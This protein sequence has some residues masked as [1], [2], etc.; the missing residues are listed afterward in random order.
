M[1]KVRKQNLGS[2]NLAANGT[3]SFDLP[4]EFI[5]ARYYL[6]LIGELNVTVITTNINESPQRL[7]RRIDLVGDGETLQTWEGGALFAYNAI[8][9]GVAPS[10]QVPATGVAVNAFRA[11]LPLPLE[12]IRSRNPMETLLRTNRF[13]TLQLRTTWG[14]VADLVSAGT[15]TL[16]NTSVN[17][18]A[19]ELMNRPE[20]IG[21]VGDR[22]LIV[23]RLTATFAA[24]T[25]TGRVSLPR[26]HKVRGLLIRAATDANDGR[27]L[28]DTVLNNI[29]IRERLTLD[30]FNLTYDQSRRLND[31]DYALAEDVNTP[32]VGG[33][34]VQGY[35]FVDFFKLGLDYVDPRSFTEFDL[36]VDVDAS[37]HLTVLPIQVRGGV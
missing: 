17:I 8:L 1:A 13:S 19:D 26:E 23:S 10:Q 9:N 28:S 15:A 24:A 11:L 29:R 37:A 3:T 5:A 31:Y 25:T 34:R 16:Q 22:D 4:R 12:L 33:F 35:T 27:D 7:F 36:V 21:L 6:E 32:G 18:I 14:A 30:T 20:A 2:M